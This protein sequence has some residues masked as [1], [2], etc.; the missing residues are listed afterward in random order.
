MLGVR[1]ESSE[2]DFKTLNHNQFIYFLLSCHLQKKR[3]TLFCEKAGHLQFYVAEIL[4]EAS[5][6]TVSF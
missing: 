2:M 5:K 1:Q 6:Q 3:R 4:L